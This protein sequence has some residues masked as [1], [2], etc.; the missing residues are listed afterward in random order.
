MRADVLFLIRSAQRRRECDLKGVGDEGYL[1]V[2]G[3]KLCQERRFN[4]YVVLL[5]CIFLQVACVKTIMCENNFP[6]YL[7]HL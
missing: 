2:A 1:F 7:K 4:L 3:D 6:R 5:I